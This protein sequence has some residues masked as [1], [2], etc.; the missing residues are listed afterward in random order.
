VRTVTES[1]LTRT[2]YASNLIK[3]LVPYIGFRG[4][5]RSFVKAAFRCA[6]CYDTESRVTCQVFFPFHPRFSF[7][8][9]RLLAVPAAAVARVAMI[10]RPD[11]SV[12]LFGRIRKA[13]SVE[14]DSSLNRRISLSKNTPPFG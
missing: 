3:E 8:P 13:F 6:D 10:R 1:E 9:F 7:P 2:R 5:V 14:P 4:Q 12:N 11:W